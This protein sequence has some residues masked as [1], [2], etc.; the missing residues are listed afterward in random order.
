MSTASLPVPPALLPGR[1]PPMIFPNTASQL[2]MLSSRLRVLQR[3][4]SALDTSSTDRGPAP[5]VSSSH[6]RPVQSNEPLLSNPGPSRPSSRDASSPASE[7]IRIFH[8]ARPDVQLVPAT[9]PLA[10]VPPS[11]PYRLNFLLPSQLRA[12]AACALQR[13]V[14]NFKVSQSKDNSSTERGPRIGQ[15]AQAA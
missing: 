14:Y 6:A 12:M 15:A 3:S 11:R 4:F 9:Y 1:P 8:N 10:P 7:I 2:D 5:A 13:P